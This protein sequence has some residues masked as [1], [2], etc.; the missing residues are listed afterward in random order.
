MVEVS[1]C[2][3]GNKPLPSSPGVSTPSKCTQ[4]EAHQGTITEA[5]N[6]SGELSSQAAAG[7][8][9]TVSAM[10]SLKGGHP[11]SFC[12]MPDV[13]L[14]EA[15]FLLLSLNVYMYVAVWACGVLSR[16]GV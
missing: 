16:Q 13:H 2:S 9:T 7:E 8:M 1:T 11:V 14:L 6:P 5:T 15:T 4:S 12:V 10:V 3:S